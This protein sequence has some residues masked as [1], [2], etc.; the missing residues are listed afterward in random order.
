MNRKLFN[1]PC[2]VD[3]LV[4][5]YPVTVKNTYQPIST[6][7]PIFALQNTGGNK[8][9]NSTNQYFEAIQAITQFGTID[10]NKFLLLV[11]DSGKNK[12]EDTENKILDVLLDHATPEEIETYLGAEKNPR[13]ACRTLLKIAKRLK[14]DG[15]KEEL[16]LL[17]DRA[18]ELRKAQR[19]ENRESVTSS[20]EIT[21]QNKKIEGQKKLM[22]HIK[23]NFKAYDKDG[24]GF[25]SL[26]EIQQAQS[27][28]FDGMTELSEEAKQ[29]LATVAKRFNELHFANI[30]SG[31][32][33]WHG[34]S[35]NDI[36]NLGDRLGRNE[37]LEKIADNLRKQIIKDR[38]LKDDLGFEA[39]HAYH[40]KNSLLNPS[41]YG[42]SQKDQQ[43]ANDMEEI[44]KHKMEFARLNPDKAYLSSSSIF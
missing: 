36:N 18:K 37:S 17:V 13:K 7:A 4:Q 42:L 9:E 21:S 28:D 16:T 12:K 29:E 19:T 41:A 32:G 14:R 15:L 25:I 22:A 27:S 34:F 10:K 33:S 8:Y 1:E 43:R 31:S 38:G 44:I 6:V 23:E 2:R 30:D 5:S 40:Q 11:S 24:N 39:H 26:Q 35:E 20:S 3:F